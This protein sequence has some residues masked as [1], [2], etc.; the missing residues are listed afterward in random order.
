MVSWGKNLVTEREKIR[1]YFL[2]SSAY[3]NPRTRTMRDDPPLP[4]SSLLPPF[5]SDQ[6]RQGMECASDLKRPN[7]LEILALEPEPDDGLRAVLASPRGPF[8]SGGRL[9]GRGEGR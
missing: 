7:L 8:K 9:W 4:P 2:F 6:P 3:Q 5:L 1:R